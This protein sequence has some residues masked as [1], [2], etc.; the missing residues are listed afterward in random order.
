M[1]LREWKD[2]NGKKVDTGI[3]AVST[4]TTVNTSS[5]FKSRF[6][7][8]LD[9]QIKHRSKSVDS[10][11]I[12]K[13][14]DD[15]FHYV[16]HCSTGYIKYDK[17][18]IVYIGQQTE[19]WRMRAY[20]D[21]ELKDDRLGL[22]YEEL[23]EALNFYLNLPTVGTPDYNNLLQEWIDAKGKKVSTA[24][25][26]A[27]TSSSQPVS[28]TTYKDKLQK[29]LDYHISQIPNCTDGKVIDY[30]IDSIFDTEDKAG[31]SYIERWVADGETK[32]NNIM[33]SARY[34]KLDKDWV[35]AVYKD[36]TRI[37]HETGKPGAGFNDFIDV[38]SS[39]LDLP[40]KST[41]EYKDLLESMTA[42]KTDTS[43]ADDFKLYE[44]LWD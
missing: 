29:L 39:Q 1:R 26:P 10:Y 32:I 4:P 40:A 12:K 5:G 11:E 8:L 31:F 28:N 7:K 18:V 14:T 42:Y 13:L 43:F 22:G 19:A 36:N 35:L 6:K 16:E 24:S 30:N 17:E 21:G 33:I 34:Y 27:T 38:L 9:Y 15:E 23:I 37:V 25:S 2:S 20:L 41:Q 44:N 3:P